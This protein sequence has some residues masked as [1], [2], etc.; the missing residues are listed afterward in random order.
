MAK[1]TSYFLIRKVNPLIGIKL[2]A[3]NTLSKTAVETIF[4]SVTS[5]LSA[6]SLSKQSKIRTKFYPFFNNN[7]KITIVIVDSNISENSTRDKII[8]AVKY[9]AVC[10]F[11]KLLDTVSANS[12]RQIYIKKHSP[13]SDA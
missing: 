9:S 1:V 6:V 4:L 2:I 11:L 13:Q 10:D 3:I 12:Y 5:A 7:L 8:S